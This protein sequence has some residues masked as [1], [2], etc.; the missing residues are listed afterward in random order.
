MPDQIAFGD[1][2]VAIDDDGSQIRFA[3]GEVVDGS[4][5]NTEDYRTTARMHGYGDDTL[6]L[7]QEHELLHIALSH[8]L[9]VESPTIELLRKGNASVGELYS[10]RLEEAAV[11]AIQHFARSLGVDLVNRMKTVQSLEARYRQALVPRLVGFTGE[12][13]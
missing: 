7:C 9:G 8:W 2:V 12:V 4:P 11:L 3:N 13:L 10:S 1:V 5:E 6:K